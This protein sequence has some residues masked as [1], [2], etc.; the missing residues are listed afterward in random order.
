MKPLMK[1]VQY[2]VKRCISYFAVG[3]THPEF[4][5]ILLMI[6]QKFQMKTFL[7]LDVVSDNSSSVLI[8]E[9]CTRTFI[10]RNLY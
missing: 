7:Q 4:R 1:I 9:C 5:L 6:A 8:F 10:T 2:S 3:T